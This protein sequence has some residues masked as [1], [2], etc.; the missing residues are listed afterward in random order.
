MAQREGRWARLAWAAGRLRA[1]PPQEL[2][3]R[4]REQILR[5]VDR[6][7]ALAR[8]A[9]E[10][11]PALLAEPPPAWPIDG[12][13]LAA[14]RDGGGAERLEAE[15]EAL[16]AGSFTMLGR[17][18]PAGARS[19]WTLDPPSGERWP[20]RAYTYDIRSRRDDGL[21]IKLVWELGRL[22]HLQ[23]LA[24]RARL[25][26]DARCR[27][28]CLEDLGRWIDD[29]PPYLGVGYASG[30]ELACRVAS[31]LVITGLLG[32]DTIP[33][34]LRGM[35]WRMLSAHGA[36]LARY[37]SL[38]S[39]ANN[40]RVAELGGL[41]LL[42]CL[43]PELPGAAAWRE[44]GLSGLAAE[45]PR[46]IL[47]DGV[48]AEQT[49]TYQAFTMEWLLLARRA[50]A[51]AGRVH[52]ARIDER[53]AAGAG[54]LSAL[55]DG[56]GHHPPIGD[57]DEGVVLRTGL[58][59]EDYPASIT[60]AV[61][62]A[63]DRPELAC[64]GGPDLRVA[65]LGLRPSSAAPRVPR[66]LCF[67]EGGYSVLRAGGP[68]RPLLVFDHG[69]LGLA[70]LRAH[71]HAD[72]LSIWLHLGG[73]PVIGEFGT[74]RYNG[75][76][77]WRR[78]AR[79]TPAHSTI[80]IDGRDQSVQSSGFAW[81]SA[82]DCTLLYSGPDAAAARH[83]GY[84]DL[85]VIH[86]RELRLSEGALAVCDHLG[87]SGVHDVLLCWHFAADLSLEAEGASW[88]L[89]RGGQPVL[90]VLAE[91]PG[92]APRSYLGGDPERAAPGFGY[93]A[94]HY[95]RLRPA[96]ALVFGGRLQLPARLSVTFAF[97]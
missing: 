66:S 51:S 89:R 62:A 64:G 16:L 6:R 81:A 47:A 76:P 30:I 21:D 48:G 78:W 69:P 17:T 83:E 1:M 27:E 86:R 15:T 75:A 53:L 20:A 92:L 93:T 72:A 61:A 65:L 54:F 77:D 22:Q 5:R 46:Q 50:A 52:S 2:P 68:L 29:N 90:R 9:V 11:P 33:E 67:A 38:Y 49:P 32:P 31:A 59:P 34:R 3:H 57:D 97:S 87:G 43:A 85:G 96:P 7:G 55:H 56:G 19:D 91:T 73:R 45:A 12:E 35:I 25:A 28:A 13:A 42:G 82:A 26:G 41:T 74:Y 24:L 94:P 4:L 14:A 40:H 58:G 63:L 8:R 18:W 23:L 44:E 84:R 95:N 37:P 79:S 80:C 88:V 70:P 39:S 36:W 71:G 10:L 60:R